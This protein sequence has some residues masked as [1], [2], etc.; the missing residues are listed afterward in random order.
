MYTKIASWLPKR[1]KAMLVTIA[2][3]GNQVSV[4]VAMFLTAEL[5]LVD[6]LGFHGWDS[7]AF[8]LYGIIYN[9]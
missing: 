4:V 9:L 6:W 8:Y 7:T 1:E 5:C 3:T 2:T